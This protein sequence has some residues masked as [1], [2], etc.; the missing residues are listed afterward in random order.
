MPVSAQE[1][2]DQLGEGANGGAD[3]SDTWRWARRRSFS[4]TLIEAK[5]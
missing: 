4:R 3:E 5:P 2:L 1:S